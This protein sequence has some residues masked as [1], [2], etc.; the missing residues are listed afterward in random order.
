MVTVWQVACGG[1]VRDHMSVRRLFEESRWQRVKAHTWVTVTEG[2]GAS[3]MT[4]LGGL[5]P[6]PEAGFHDGVECGGQGREKSEM[7]PIFLFE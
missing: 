4:P 7:S 3:P 6:V 2:T 5:K 1:T